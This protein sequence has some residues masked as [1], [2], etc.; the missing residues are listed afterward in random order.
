MAPNGYMDHGLP[1]VAKGR[2]ERA[3]GC[4]SRGCGDRLSLHCRWLLQA[5]YCHGSISHNMAFGWFSRALRFPYSWS[6]CKAAV[7]IFE[8]NK[9]LEEL[10]TLWN[11]VVIVSQ[12][13]KR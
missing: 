10:V 4:E 9:Y 2:S 12:I 5:L 11:N 3:V 13:H 8:F 1:N 6:L 7:S